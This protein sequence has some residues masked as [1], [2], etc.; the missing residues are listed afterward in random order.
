MAR[1][2]KTAFDLDFE[3]DMKDPEFRAAYQLARARIDAIDNLVRGLD[4]ARQAQRMTKAELARRMS[5]QPEVVRRL[6][7]M[8]TPN[9]TMNTVVCAAQALGLRVELEKEASRKPARGRRT[10]AA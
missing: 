7:S 8:E 2:Q 9:P 1:R 4:E 3:R 6:F 5:V 10:S